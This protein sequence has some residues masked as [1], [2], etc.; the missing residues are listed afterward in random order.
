MSENP[1]QT[2]HLRATCYFSC[3]H[4]PFLFQ[5]FPFGALSETIQG[6]EKGLEIH[7]G[8][9]ILL[10]PVSICIRATLLPHPQP[11]HQRH[12]PGPLFDEHPLVCLTQ[13]Q[14]HS[15][16][17]LFLLFLGLPSC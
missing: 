17:I 8:D 7:T 4:L 11:R 13:T 9:H 10:G 1:G 3:Q 5:G 14:N 12:L 2:L 6:P 16:S 15:A